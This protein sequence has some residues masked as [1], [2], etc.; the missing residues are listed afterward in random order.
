MRKFFALPV[1]LLLVPAS[2]MA[3]NTPDAEVF[4]GI[5][6]LSTSVQ[7]LQGL[8]TSVNG[9][10]NDWLGIKADVSAMYGNMG[11]VRLRA[12]TFTV[13]PQ[14][15][16]RKNKRI[17]PFAHALFGGAHASAGFLGLSFSDSSFAMNFGGGL[18]VV[19]HKNFA[20]RVFQVDAV[21]TRFSHDVSTDPRI[22][23]GV[24]FRFGKK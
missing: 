24:V 19:A 3:Q 10:V 12:Y 7:S 16:Y 20:I 1:L 6:V 21:V 15:S 13:G 9:N 14:F 11:I 23:A 22:S 4:G 8:D 2:A 18:D 17:V 5:S